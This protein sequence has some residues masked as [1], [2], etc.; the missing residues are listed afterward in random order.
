MNKWYISTDDGGGRNLHRKKPVRY[1][2]IW[3]SNNSDYQYKIINDSILPELTWGDVP[4]ELR[5]NN[6]NSVRL[7]NVTNQPNQDEYDLYEDER[8]T[9]FIK[10]LLNIVT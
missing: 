10:H 7:V 2:G 4:Y 1:H 3:I 9:M 6:A 5:L 8:V